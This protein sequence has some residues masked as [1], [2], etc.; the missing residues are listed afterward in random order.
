M[1]RIATVL[2]AVIA[3]LALC[4]TAHAQVVSGTYSASV[5][6]QATTAAVQLSL[7]AASN[8]RLKV[9]RICVSSSAATASAAVT[10]T[11]RRTTTASSGGTALTAEGT[12]ATAVSKLTP[13]SANFTGV[14]RLNGTPGTDG[15]TLDQ[16]GFVVAEIAAGT[17]DPPGP[18]PFC[19]Q[20]GMDGRTEP[21]TVNSGVT[22]GLYVLL[23]AAGAGGLNS[24]AIS[25]LFTAEE[26]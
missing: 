1:K 17:A 24:G 12:G 2:L 5:G 26:G 21:I 8:R 6:A 4:S 14:A 9:Y 18:A 7:E 11:V 23:S 13:N 10:V 15:A 20:Y 3:G 16:F 22:N 25:I 19:V